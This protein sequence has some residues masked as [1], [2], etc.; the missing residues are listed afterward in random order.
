MKSNKYNWKSS[1]ISSDYLIKD[2]IKNLNETNLQIALV[3]KKK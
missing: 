2:A 3:A 1:I